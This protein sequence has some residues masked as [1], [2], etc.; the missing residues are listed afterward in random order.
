MKLI[1]HI[2]NNISNIFNKITK[3]NPTW[4]QYIDN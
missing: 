1:N 4:E 2:K 3:N